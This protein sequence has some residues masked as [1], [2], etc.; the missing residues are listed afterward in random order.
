MSWKKVQDWL[1][2]LSG[3]EDNPYAPRPP[4][5]QQPQAPQEMPKYFTPTEGVQGTGGPMI[6]WGDVGRGMAGA[7]RS[8]VTPPSMTATQQPQAATTTTAAAQ[9]QAPVNQTYGG[10][11]GEDLIFQAQMKAFGG[12]SGIYAGAGDPEQNAARYRSALEQM[13]QTQELTRPMSTAG[14]A[15]AREQRNAERK[16]MLQAARVGGKATERVETRQADTEEFKQ[17]E[18][19]VNRSLKGLQYESK[20]TADSLSKAFNEMSEDEKKRMAPV[21]QQYTYHVNHP[22]FQDFEKEIALR[23]AQNDSQG[24]EYQKMLQDAGNDYMKRIGV[25]ERFYNVFRQQKNLPPVS[26]MPKA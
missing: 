3:G 8:F 16:A 9:P 1:V 24:M 10:L 12:G 21:V 26:F 13:A 11:T 19:G 2:S 6:S 17:L 4:S 22:D 7:A 15:E 14:R 5:G 20:Q 23:I 18:A 25:Q